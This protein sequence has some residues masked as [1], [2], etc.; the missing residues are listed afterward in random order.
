[1]EPSKLTD[2]W[3]RSRIALSVDGPERDNNASHRY[4][5]TIFF[6]TSQEKPNGISGGLGMFAVFVVAP[7]NRNHQA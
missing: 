5:D 1:M 3:L 4:A 7:K 2:R 6:L